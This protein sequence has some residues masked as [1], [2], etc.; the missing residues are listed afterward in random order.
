M[1]LRF[2]SVATC[3]STVRQLIIRLAPGKI[4][5]IVVSLVRSQNIK[6]FVTF[7]AANINIACVAVNRFF[8]KSPVNFDSKMPV[9]NMLRD[10]IELKH[11]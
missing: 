11:S 6:I 10:E 7:E 3:P 5:I 2:S 9:V 1:F 8:R 4:T